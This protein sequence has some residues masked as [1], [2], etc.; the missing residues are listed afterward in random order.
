MDFFVSL[1]LLKR[2]KSPVLSS[3]V[4]NLTVALVAVALLA[5]TWEI[6]LG[7]A[8]H[9]QCVRRY[10]CPTTGLRNGIR[11]PIAEDWYQNPIPTNA[12]IWGDNDQE[13]Y[14]RVCRDA[15]LTWQNAAS[16]VPADS[17]VIY[18]PNPWGQFQFQLQQNIDDR[19]NQTPEKEGE[20]WALWDPSFDLPRFRC[21]ITRGIVYFAADPRLTDPRRDFWWTDCLDGCLQGPEFYFVDWPTIAFHEYGHSLALSHPGYP[22]TS[23]LMNDHIEYRTVKRVPS[24]CEIDAL[25]IWIDDNFGQS[26]IDSFY[27][28]NLGSHVR[29]VWRAVA[30][31]GCI[32]YRVCFV[33]ASMGQG[34]GLI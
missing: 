8:A 13:L 22:D 4:R 5:P 26:V 14:D 9:A 12:Y 20:P 19:G 23:S 21:V 30:E 10:I 18:A 32:K 33:S 11:L 34:Q 27:V 7:A 24:Q 2:G 29:C 31:S 16:L 15:L 3:A 28:E 25:E 6:M 17:I 1:I